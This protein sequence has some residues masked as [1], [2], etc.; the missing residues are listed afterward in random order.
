MKLTVIG[1]TSRT[2]AHVLTEAVSRGHTVTAFTRRPELL[3]EKTPLA[4]VVVGDGRDAD[5][6]RCAV[7][8][9]DAVIA[10]VKAS[11]RK[12]PHVTAE[13]AEVIVGAM[14][15]LGVKRLVMTSAYP[16]V[17]EKPRLPM[18]II[19]RVLR[20]GY[21]DMLAMER[22]LA[23]SDLDW[24]VARLNGL[25]DRP[26]AGRVQISRGLLDRPATLSR[27]DAAAAL[28]DLVAD[29]G[30]ARAAA[31]IAGTQAPKQER[32]RPSPVR[33]N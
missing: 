15:T 31:N 29:A 11:S 13:V 1:A 9:A 26:A 20:E 27:A 25:L 7:A 10:I 16:V 24:T 6:V 5:A 23:A 30:F 22:I 28:L 12:G 14:S 19:R 21:E 17:A 4:R 18:A 2:G 3:S 32:R 33:T 8:S